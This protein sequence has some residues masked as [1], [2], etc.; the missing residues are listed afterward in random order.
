MGEGWARVGCQPLPPQASLHLPPGST[1]SSAP[2]VTR[3][4]STS[5][6]CPCDGETGGL[7]RPG[8]PLSPPSCSAPTS[9]REQFHFQPPGPSLAPALQPG[10][11]RLRPGLGRLPPHP[12]PTYSPP[13]PGWMWFTWPST[14]WGCRARR[15]TLTL[16]RFWP[17]STTT[18]SSCSLAR[19]AGPREGRTARVHCTVGLL[20]SREVRG[21]PRV[22]QCRPGV[23][24]S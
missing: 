7:A 21:L 9:L 18:G 19:Y 2:C 15:S 4:R 6:G 1:C 17:L 13:C 11:R 14:T 23:G 12:S 5:S 22:T 20:R 16:R 10:P 8:P 24:V 3:A